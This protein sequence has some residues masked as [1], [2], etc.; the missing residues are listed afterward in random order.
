MMKSIAIVLLLLSLIPAVVAESASL[1]TPLSSDDKAKFDKI[2]EPIMKIYNFIK[3]IASVVA[4]LFLLGAGIAYMASG[5]D[6]RRRDQAKH[7][8]TFVV[9][10]LVVIWGSP[11]IVGL[12][13]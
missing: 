11:F 10:G 6:P 8:M 13:I 5:A 1:D 9:I 2:L 4:G 3:Y 12:L 7:M